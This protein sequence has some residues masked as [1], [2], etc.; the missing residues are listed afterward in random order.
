M[1]YFRD[2][3]GGAALGSGTPKLHL[4]ISGP[5]TEKV[6][7]LRS[8]PETSSHTSRALRKRKALTFIFKE[9]NRRHFPLLLPGQNL[10]PEEN[11]IPASCSQFLTM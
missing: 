3:P 11:G 7:M 4:N 2:L 5:S 6:R 9:K 8:L 1:A 10:I